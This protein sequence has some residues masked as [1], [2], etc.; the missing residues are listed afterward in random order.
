MAAPKT[1]TPTSA[2]LPPMSHEAAVSCYLAFAHITAPATTEERAALAQAT[3]QLVT[4][5]R[6][7]LAPGAAPMKSARAPVLLPKKGSGP[8]PSPFV[9]GDRYQSVQGDVFT[10][11]ET[12]WH[13][14]PDMP[15]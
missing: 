9:I 6:A 8:W 1:P 14:L 2:D 11:T 12:G 4:D 13:K 3:T 15:A 5:A 10:L 7:A